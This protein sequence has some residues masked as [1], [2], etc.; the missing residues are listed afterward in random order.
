MHPAGLDAFARRDA[1]R[2]GIYAFENAP[3]QLSSQYEK[4]FRQNKTAWDVFERHPPSAKKTVIFWIMSAKKEETQLRRLHHVIERCVKGLKV[5]V[6]E[7]KPK[8]N[9]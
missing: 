4:M 2:T 8:D 3:R 6:L 1:K 5:G 7:T 9:A